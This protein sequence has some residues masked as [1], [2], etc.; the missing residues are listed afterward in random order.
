MI[1]RGTKRQIARAVWNCAEVRKHIYEEVVKQIHKEC[2]SMCVKGSSKETKKRK[3]SCLRKTD[4][5]S[6][7]NFSFDSLI[8]ELRER[9]PLFLLVLKTAA[10]QV[11]DETEKWKPAVGVA[12]AVCLRNRSRNMI[13]L[14]LF[15]AIMNRHSGFMVIH[16]IAKLNIYSL[17]LTTVH[18]CCY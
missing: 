4:K 17:F 18:L 10:F 15:L 2:V 9:A 13:A 16:Y 14:Q 5:E 1:C 11:K 8:K 7:V 12:A 3:D 6:I